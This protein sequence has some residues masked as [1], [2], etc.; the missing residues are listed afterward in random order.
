MSSQLCNNRKIKYFEEMHTMTHWGTSWWYKEA[1]TLSLI[2]T[3][4]TSDLAAN[5]QTSICSLGVVV[6][7]KKKMPYVDF[8]RIS[9]S[10]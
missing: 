9:C 5:I 7:K 1:S 8:S 6:G 10:K 2:H 3:A 4:T